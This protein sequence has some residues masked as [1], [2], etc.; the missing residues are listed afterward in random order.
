M[1]SSP[2]QSCFI[3][4]HSSCRVVISWAF[5]HLLF[6]AHILASEPFIATTDVHSVPCK[7]VA[8]QFVRPPSSETDAMVSLVNLSDP[9]TFL[10][11]HILSTFSHCSITEFMYLFS[12]SF[13]KQGSKSKQKSSKCYSLR[14]PCV[15]EM[16]IVNKNHLT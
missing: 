3:L 9:T 13:L 2:E 5:I 4:I 8:A 16:L 15:F 7:D 10:N 11:P 1:K 12:L 6:K 14:I